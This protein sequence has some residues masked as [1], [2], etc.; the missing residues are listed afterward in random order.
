MS[1]DDLI[2]RLFDGETL[3]IKDIER[4]QL[5][6]S[7]REGELTSDEID[8]I[9]TYFSR[10]YH[11]GEL[12]KIPDDCYIDGKRWTDGRLTELGFLSTKRDPYGGVLE[13]KNQTINQPLKYR[14]RINL[15][16]DES[17]NGLKSSPEPAHLEFKFWLQERIELAAAGK[18]SPRM[19]QVMQG[20]LDEKDAATS[21]W[22]ELS[23]KIKKELEKDL[24]N[25]KILGQK[26][27][28]H[29]SSCLLYTS[30]SPRDRTRSRMPSS[31]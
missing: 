21:K 2:S 15:R 26:T 11:Q 16:E 27:K 28:R 12:L 7:L 10:N 25:E 31:A 18:G 3:T 9:D 17:Q 6:G 4:N 1:E 5:F 23:E 20:K 13:W 30:P 8:L 19:L 24:L 14:P 29:D 22:A